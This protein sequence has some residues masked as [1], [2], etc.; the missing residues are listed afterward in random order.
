MLFV[1]AKIAYKALNKRLSS[2]QMN[3]R[4]YDIC[5]QV[6]DLSTSHPTPCSH[7]SLVELIIN[8]LIDILNIYYT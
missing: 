1:K 8:Q 6:I 5:T 7:G 3:N 2:E 4:Y